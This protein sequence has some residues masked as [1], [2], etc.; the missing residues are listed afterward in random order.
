MHLPDNAVLLLIDV[1]KG[2]DLPLWGQRNNPDA[3]KNIGR[4][5]SD[6][7]K[8]SAPVVHV[9]HMSAE[10]KSPLRPGQTGNEFKPEATPLPGE[11]IIEKCVNSCFIGT[12]LETYLRQHNFDTLV[13]VGLTTDHCVSTTT[14]MSGNLGFKTYLVADATA[15]F[16]RTTYDGQHLPADLVHSYALASLHNEF[17][18]V[19]ACAELLT[20]KA[21]LISA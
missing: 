3:E 2:F 7:R 8:R 20:N 12:N 13:I 19:V 9:R 15:T 17:A 1:Q 11:T 5:L 14:R 4:L 21:S 10:P 6:W 16:D 18:T